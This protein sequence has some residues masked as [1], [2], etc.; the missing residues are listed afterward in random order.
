VDIFSE[1]ELREAI[2]ALPEVGRQQSARTLV[3]ALEGAG[4]QQSAYW[5]NRVRPFINQFWPKNPAVRTSAISE[6]FAQLCIAS[7]DAFVEAF[8][9]LRVWLVRTDQIG[10]VPH[11]LTMSGL[12]TRYSETALALLDAV[13]GDNPRWPPSDLEECLEQIKAANPN[14]EDDSRYQRLRQL[15]RRLSR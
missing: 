10:I 4:D 11:K 12:C 7:G 6:V 2:A 8:S 9:V 1:A 13:I 3:Y 14:L 5:K 15:L